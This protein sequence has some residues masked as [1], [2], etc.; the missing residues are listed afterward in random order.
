[1]DWVQF[2]Q[3]PWQE[4]DTAGWQGR[5]HHNAMSVPDTPKQSFK[6]AQGSWACDIHL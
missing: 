3:R 1:M 5:S 2:T 4:Q 6:T